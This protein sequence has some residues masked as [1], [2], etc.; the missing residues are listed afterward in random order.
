MIAT[1]FLFTCFTGMLFIGGVISQ[2]LFHL[3]LASI[4]V[5]LP[6]YFVGMLIGGM[7]ERTLSLSDVNAI[8]E[9]NASFSMR[10]VV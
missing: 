5:M 10:S 7:I 2:S 6:T 3:L 4:A 9:T 1:A 8:D